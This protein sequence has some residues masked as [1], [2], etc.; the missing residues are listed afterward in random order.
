VPLFGVSLTLTAIALVNGGI[1]VGRLAGRP[2]LRS[3]LR[4]LAWAASASE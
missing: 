1:V 3:G 2:M 4:H